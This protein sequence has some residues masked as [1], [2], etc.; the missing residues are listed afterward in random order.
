MTGPRTVP[1]SRVLEG[2][3]TKLVLV[4]VTV[5]SKNSTLGARDLFSG[6][7]CGLTLPRQGRRSVGRGDACRGG[8]GG[9]C[10]GGKYGLN[11]HPG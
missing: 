5:K 3:G 8:G 2:E 6:L 10:A 1:A 4:T 11:Q 7:L 9:D